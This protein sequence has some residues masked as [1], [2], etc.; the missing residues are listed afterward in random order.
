MIIVIFSIAP[1]KIHACHLYILCYINT[2]REAVR[3]YFVR[4]FFTVS[5]HQVENQKHVTLLC[6]ISKTNIKRDLLQEQRM[7]SAQY[8]A[9]RP[10]AMIAII[11]KW[12]NDTPSSSVRSSRASLSLEKSD[13]ALES[14]TYCWRL[15]VKEDLPM[16]LSTSWWWWLEYQVQKLVTAIS[17]RHRW[18]FK[19]IHGCVRTLKSTR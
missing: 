3:D 5:E 15:D 7:N 17:R 9:V 16:M 4:A 6:R 11:W 1:I 8:Q 12:N 2:E 10:L 13:G 14:R 19:S 18:I